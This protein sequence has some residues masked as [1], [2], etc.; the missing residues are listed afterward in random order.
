M[1][2]NTILFIATVLAHSA[3]SAISKSPPPQSDVEAALREV[4]EAEKREAEA[5]VNPSLGVKI[6]WTV[7][8]VE[9]R[10]VPGDAARPYAGTIR[11]IVESK[12]PELD[13]YATD[14]FERSYEYLWDIETSAWVLQ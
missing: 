5:D 12:T 11:F 14:R 1:R 13:G 2:P 10:P 7:D 9:V 4:A 8:S 6:T 3:C